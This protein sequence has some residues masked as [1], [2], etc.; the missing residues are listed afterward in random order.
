MPHTC[1]GKRAGILRGREK[2]RE[3][4]RERKKEKIIVTSETAK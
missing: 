4:E 2:E 3:R 1:C